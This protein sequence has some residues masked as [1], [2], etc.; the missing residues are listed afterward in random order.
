MKK[1]IINGEL[2]TI[3]D[4]EEGIRHH[5]EPNIAVEEDGIVYPVISKT[6][7]Y[8][9][10]GVF[11]D[12]CM[13]TFVNASDKPENYKV[14]NLK[15]IDFSNTKSMKE[16]I[17]KNAELREMEETVLVSPDNI[18]N[19]KPKPTDLPE[20]IALKQA[21]NQ[22][23]IDINKYAYRFGDNFNNDRRLFE[24]PTITL[25]KLKT[26]AEALDM[27]CYIIIEDIDKDV[28]NPIGS[29]V[30]VRITNIEEGEADD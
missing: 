14:D 6:N 5:E 18:F 8:G 26:I 17:E 23:H 27:S 3:Y 22:K 1:A 4:F 13:A 24:K 9:Q 30:K 2:Y 21:V 28:P 16:Q 15:V 12:G 11:V 19:A 20:M 7:A 10:T 29:Q 25:S